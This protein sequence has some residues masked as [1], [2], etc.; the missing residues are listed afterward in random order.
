MNATE[1]F[2]E[3][4]RQRRQELKLTQLELAEKLGVTLQSVY[5]YESGTQFPRGEV[6]NIICRIL[7]LRPFGVELDGDGGSAEDLTPQ[8]ALRVLAKAHGF[9]LVKS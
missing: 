1:I 6:F 4:V 2:A 8:D 3:R 5:G 7:K 9:R